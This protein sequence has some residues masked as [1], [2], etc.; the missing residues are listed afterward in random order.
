MAGS[1]IT[2]DILANQ[3]PGPCT[4]GSIGDTDF[5]RRRQGTDWESISAIPSASSSGDMSTTADALLDL[6]GQAEVALSQASLG[7]HSGKARLGPEETLVGHSN[8]AFQYPKLIFDVDNAFMLGSP[9]AVFLMVRNQTKP[10]STSFSLEGCSRVFNIF[11]PYDPVAYR[12][13]PLLDPR[14]A[15]FEPRIMVHW[16][17]G[18]RV[19]Y[20]TKRLWRKLI[21][22]TM[23]TQ[24]TVIEKLE[25]GIAEMGLLDSTVD[26]P[27]EDNQSQPSSGM[28]EDD[29]SATNIVTGK[30]NQGR[31]IDYMLQEKEIEAANEYVAALAAHSCYWQEKDLSLFIARQIYLSRLAHEQALHFEDLLPVDDSDEN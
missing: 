25:A 12:I 8:S 20:Q 2:W 9:I 18:F 22:T 23:Q 29:R 21:Q 4:T 7:D 1:I 24:R 5:D 15:E 6:P 30:L 3:C 17:G 27:D 11:H 10:L 19:Q 28:V 16:N 31:R 13:E 14:N 26:F